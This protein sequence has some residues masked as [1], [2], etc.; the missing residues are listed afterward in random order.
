[1]GGQLQIGDLLDG[2]KQPLG[3]DPLGI[4]EELVGGLGRHP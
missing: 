3:A 4:A 1:M 2:H